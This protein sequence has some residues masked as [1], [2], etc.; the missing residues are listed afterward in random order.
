MIIIIPAQ[1]PNTLSDFFSDRRVHVK[2]FGAAYV[3]IFT[4][5]AILARAFMVKTTW[6]AWPGMC[7]FAFPF[8]FKLF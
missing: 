8:I 3:A 7:C 5:I 2:Y 6:I 1:F 4:R